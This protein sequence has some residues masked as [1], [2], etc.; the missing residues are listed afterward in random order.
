MVFFRHVGRQIVFVRVR[1]PSGW[2]LYWSGPEIFRCF[3]QVLAD[4]N[5]GSFGY[6]CGRE[7]GLT[8][9]AHILVIAASPVFVLLSFACASGRNRSVAGACAAH[10]GTG[11]AVTT[12]AVVIERKFA[13]MELAF[14]VYADPIV[15]WS[16]VALCFQTAARRFAILTPSLARRCLSGGKHALAAT[17]SALFLWPKFTNNSPTDTFDQCAGMPA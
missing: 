3:V 13:W 9:A 14:K 10:A 11:A 7:D 17:Y 6:G 2:R 16:C 12:S 8:L 1:L 4:V 15:M 5:S